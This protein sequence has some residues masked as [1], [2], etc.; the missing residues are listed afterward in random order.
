[1]HIEGDVL[2]LADVRTELVFSLYHDDG[3]ALG[4][5]EVAHLGSKL[6]DIGAARVEESL[7]LCAYLH[8]GHGAEPPGIAAVLPLATGIRSG[9]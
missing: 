6:S 3:T 5:L 1:M 2:A 4:Y 9:T 7:V 8:L